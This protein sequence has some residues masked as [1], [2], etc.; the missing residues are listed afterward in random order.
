MKP[1]TIFT[2]VLLFIIIV[3]RTYAQQD[4]FPILKGLYLSQRPPGMTPEIFAHELLSGALGLSFTPDGNE[5]YYASRSR[6]MFMRRENDEWTKPHT[7]SFSGQYRDWDLNLSPD[8]KKLFFTSMRPVTKNGKPTDHADIW[9]VHRTETGWSEPSN[10]G[11]PINTGRNELHPTISK[12]GNLYYFCDF[13]TTSKADIYCSKFVDGKYTT[14]EKLRSK[15]NSES[16]D[17]D[18]FI[19][20]DESYLIFHSYRPGG[21]GEADLYIS[22]RNE[23]G[24]WRAA[25]NLGEKINTADHD[26]CGR[27]SHDGKYLFFKRLKMNPRQSDNYWVDVKIIEELKSDGM[28]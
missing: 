11:S 10:L 28:R 2:G 27:V 3:F 1:R 18:P 19:A 8:G 12:N 25:I 16:S 17:L 21:F 6:I 7:V 15:I 5:L 20:P 26:L 14:P 23:D 9:V 24:S 4:D 22:F 13:D